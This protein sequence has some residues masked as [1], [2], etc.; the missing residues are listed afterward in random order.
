[1]P[2]NAGGTKTKVKDGRNMYS[3]SRPTVQYTISGIFTL[4]SAL[5]CHGY[6]L[7]CLSAEHPHCSNWK[8]S[9]TVCA[10]MSEISVLFFVRTSLA[11][12]RTGDECMRGRFC[13]SRNALFIKNNNWFIVH[14]H[15]RILLS[16]QYLPQSS[17]ATHRVTY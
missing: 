10:C 1:V 13:T 7:N 4:P 3:P 8:I 12:K 11:P 2:T 9:P 15:S 17:A 5:L 16:P 14:S 6:W